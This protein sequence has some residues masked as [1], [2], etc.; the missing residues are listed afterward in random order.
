MA[1]VAHL[2][3]NVFGDSDH[4]LHELNGLLKDVGV[5]ALQNILLTG[6]CADLER[7]VDLTVPKILARD[8][9]AHDLK[10]MNGLL[11]GFLQRYKYSIL[12][13]LYQF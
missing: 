3:L 4:V 1:V 6:I 8:R 7:I 12:L 13:V 10:M 2:L 9:L 11:H 5:D